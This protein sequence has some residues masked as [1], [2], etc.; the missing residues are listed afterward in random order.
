M[1][2]LWG[3]QEVERAWIRGL[4]HRIGHQVWFASW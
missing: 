4:R 3:A 2:L 1:H